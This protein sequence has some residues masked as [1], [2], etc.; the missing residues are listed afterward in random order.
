VTTTS[1]SARFERPAS[2]K[3]ELIRRFAPV[4]SARRHLAKMALVKPTSFPSSVVRSVVTSI[5]VSGLRGGL[6]CFVYPGAKVEVTRR[7]GSR[8][9][10]SGK[11]VF[12]SF[13]QSRDPARIVMDRNSLLRVDGDLEIGSGVA[14][15]AS[16]GAKIVIGGKSRSGAGFSADSLIFA[17]ERIVIGTDSIFAWGCNVVDSDWHELVGSAATS[18]VSIGNDCW[19]GH[20]VSVLK[21]ASVPDGCVVGAK[22]VVGRGKYSPQSL[23]AGSPAQTKRQGV[24]WRR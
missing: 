6:S 22:S 21:G 7:R 16:P 13:L 3:A 15:V 18:P 12:R 24:K 8:V 19:V 23:I 4:G 14:L 11:L 20:G 10:L 5:R 17:R 9:E 2:L 1:S